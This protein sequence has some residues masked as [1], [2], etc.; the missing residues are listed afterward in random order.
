MTTPRFWGR[1]GG[2]THGGD[3]VEEDEQEDDEEVAVG[4]ERRVGGDERHQ[5]GH[6][7]DQA[8]IQQTPGQPGR[9][10]RHRHSDILTG[11]RRR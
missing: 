6:D 3:A 5:D 2:A 7:E 8:R 10:G 1:E 9:T 11:G 4:E